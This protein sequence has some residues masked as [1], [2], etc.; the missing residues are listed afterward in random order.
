[1]RLGIVNW[2]TYAEG[3]H[4]VPGERFTKPSQT[5]PGQTLSLKEIIE[6]FVRR[7]ETLPSLGG[8]YA[9][10]E[11]DFPDDLERMDQ[12]DR[13]ELAQNLGSAI[14]SEQSRLHAKKVAASMDAT[15]NTDTTPQEGEGTKPD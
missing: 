1:M 15:Q 2:A 7:G 12:L 9:G 13:L 5:V 10:E 6:R 4:N 3:D 14:K 11:T 8:V